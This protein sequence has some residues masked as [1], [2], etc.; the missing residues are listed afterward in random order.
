MDLRIYA[1][2]EIR[3]GGGM[4]KAPD[5]SA[6]PIPRK[7]GAKPLLG[8]DTEA[9][10]RGEGEGG[11]P[12]QPASVSHP[13]AASSSTSIDA[14]QVASPPRE[15]T[16]AAR[17]TRAILPPRTPVPPPQTYGQTVAATVKL[18]E[19]RY[20]RLMEAGKPAPGRLKRRTIQDMVIEAL[21]EWF[22]RRRL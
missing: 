11:A 14:Q 21:D 18:D 2:A 3:K 5:L 6:F 15:V 8:D 22:E 10:E 9:V 7:G 16:V 4:S 17:P 19:N 12:D 1:L 20:L 13:A